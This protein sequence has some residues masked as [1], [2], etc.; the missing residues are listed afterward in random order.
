[1]ITGEDNAL[2]SA[3][4][5]VTRVIAHIK[6][7]ATIQNAAKFLLGSEGTAWTIDKAHQMYKEFAADSKGPFWK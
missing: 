2:K 7:L 6:D 3:N 1:M 5:V 4:P